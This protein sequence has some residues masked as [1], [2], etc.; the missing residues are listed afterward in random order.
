M[1]DLKKRNRK[2]PFK[3]TIWDEAILLNYYRTPA[4]FC[5]Y[6]KAQY[7]FLQTKAITLI[8]FFCLT[9][10]QE[11]TF[12]RVDDMLKEMKALW[13]HTI[14]KCKGAFLSPVPIP[15]IPND[16]CICRASTILN[17]LHMIKEKHGV[18]SSLFVDWDMG[19]PLAV[20]K[21]RYLLKNLLS[22]LG[23]SE[24]KTPYS[25]KYVAMSYL[26]NHNVPMESINEVVCYA[27]GSKMVRDRYVIS[28][29]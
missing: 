16:K 19:T 8:M 26:V 2:A 13:V 12:I 3:R 4:L 28:A 5:K 24:D 11:T 22:D 14:V 9:R 29:A 20:Y 6:D 17:L 27:K 1:R 21:A 23:F 7:K 15:F 18:K 10:I 25:F